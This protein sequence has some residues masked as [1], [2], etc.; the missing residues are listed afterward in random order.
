MHKAATHK[1]GFHRS[2]TI[3]IRRNSK[4]IIPKISNVLETEY[5]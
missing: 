1:G 4:L 3:N 5:G 2:I